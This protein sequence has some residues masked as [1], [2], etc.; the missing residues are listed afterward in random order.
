MVTINICVVSTI[1]FKVLPLFGDNGMNGSA[2]KNNV[3]WLGLSWLKS[4]KTDNDGDD[5]DFGQ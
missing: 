1:N 4:T 5:D 3:H 2:F